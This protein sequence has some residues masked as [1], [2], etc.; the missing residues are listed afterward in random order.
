MTV[1][2]NHQTSVLMQ[3]LTKCQNHKND[4]PPTPPTKVEISL[5]KEALAGKNKKGNGKFVMKTANH[6]TILP[7]ICYNPIQQTVPEQVRCKNSSYLNL[8]VL[9]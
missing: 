1:L 2:F 3:H 7:E 4:T 8:P 9:T 6:L 5:L